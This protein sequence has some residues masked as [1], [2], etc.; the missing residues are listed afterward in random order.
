MNREIGVLMNIITL[1]HLNHSRYKTFMK[2]NELN[3]VKHFTTLLNTHKIK[4]YVLRY[5]KWRKK[6]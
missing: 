3:E 5:E 6:S 2:M 4:I 1:N